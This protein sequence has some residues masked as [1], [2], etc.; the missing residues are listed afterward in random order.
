[1]DCCLYFEPIWRE[2]QQRKQKRIQKYLK[3]K[4]DAQ[5]V[6]GDSIPVPPSDPSDRSKRCFQENPNYFAFK[7]T[8]NEELPKDCSSMSTLPSCPPLFSEME[9]AGTPLVTV[10]SIRQKKHRDVP[11]LQVLYQD[12][13]S[14]LPEFIQEDD[15]Q[16]TSG[17]PQGS[18]ATSSVVNFLWQLIPFR[19]WF[20]SGGKN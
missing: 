18:S 14:P 4:S 19:S 7:K 5:K 15:L 12:T 16:D 17:T 10:E 3:N 13:P 1:L 11:L 2:E 9:G 8:W 6:L 20:S